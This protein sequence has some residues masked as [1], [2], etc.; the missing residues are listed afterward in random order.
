MSSE[1]V[2]TLAGLALLDSVSFSAFG[3]PV[4]LLLTSMKPPVARMLT[5]L[6]T[7]VAFFFF[8]GVGLM[9]G[10]GTLLES[11]SGLFETTVAHT[12]QLALGVGLFALSFRIDSKK[13]KAS[14]RAPAIPAT[15]GLGAMVALGLTTA[16]LEVATMLPYLS[17]IGILTA[18]DLPASQ[19]TPL[20]AGY[21]L[22]MVLPPIVLLVVFAVARDWLRPYLERIAK[23]TEQHGRGV[24]GWTVGIIGFLLA[25]DAIRR[26]GLIEFLTA[27]ITG[28]AS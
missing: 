8:L 11:W 18:F 26:L 17:A 28:G 10:L 20:L 21:T 12:V 25:M 1:L 19:W 15:G 22:L 16:L 5:Y 6:G 14:S 24:V 7:V 13:A 9:L 3:V 2:L 4:Y 27:W 23:W